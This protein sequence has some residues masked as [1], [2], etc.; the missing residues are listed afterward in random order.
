MKDL[1]KILGVYEWS[2]DDWRLLLY[3]VMPSIFFDVLRKKQM[4]LFSQELYQ[5]EDLINECFMAIDYLFCELASNERRKPIFKKRKIIWFRDNVL[6]C[7]EIKWYVYQTIARTIQNMATDKW[8]IK[9]PFNKNW[10][11]ANILYKWSVDWLSVFSISTDL[12]YDK[13][14]YI[15]NEYESIESDEFNCLDDVEDQY[16]FSILCN[17]IDK[18]DYDSKKIFVQRYRQWMPIWSMAKDWWISKKSM[19]TK[20]NEFNETLTKC[21]KDEKINIRAST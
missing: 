13:D 11:A 14:M 18:M 19:I 10:N 2:I 17:I 1:C 3:R 5:R 20:I 21:I 15:K 9:V 8:S 7:W 16:M 6:S 4:S 12:T